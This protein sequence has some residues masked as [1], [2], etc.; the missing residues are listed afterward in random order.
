M[1]GIQTQVEKR[2]DPRFM[3]RIAI[4]NGPY[5][6]ELLTDYTVNVSSGGLFIETSKILPV[7]TLLMIKF[8]LPD[9]ETA[10]S[11]KARVAWTNEADA[12]KKPSFPPGMGIQFLDLT[13]DDMHA[14]R[15]FVDRNELVAIW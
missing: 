3:A 5:Q 15:M 6:K 4:F 14:I 7:D 8:K 2:S 10:I 9:V 12:P 1:T 13:Q 11:C